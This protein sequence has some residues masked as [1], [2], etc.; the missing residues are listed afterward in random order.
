MLRTFLIYITAITI[1]TAALY[2]AGAQENSG[3]R[4][5]MVEFLES[6]G[7]NKAPVKKSSGS[8]V[9]LPSDNKSENLFNNNDWSEYISGQEKNEYLAAV[10][11]GNVYDDEK[12]NINSYGSIKEN[13]IY[14]NSFYTDKKY[15]QYDEDIAKS[16]VIN[17]GFWPE[18]IVLIHADGTVGNRVS[19][20]IDHDS[21]RQENRYIM[22]YHAVSD[23]EVLREVNAGEIDIKFNHSKYAVYDNTNAKGMGVD[24]TIKKGDFSLKAFG[25]I[26]RGLISVDYFKGNSS[27]GSI[28][29]SDYQFLRKS[30]YQ[31]EPFLRYDGVSVMPSGSAAY[32]LVTVTSKPSNPSTY[33]LNSVNISPSGFQ[34]YIDD[35]N[36]YNNNNAI[37]LSMD[38]GYYTKMVSGS[39]Y[40]VNF[41]TGV[42]HFL[43][44]IPDSSRIFAVYNRTGGTLDPCALSPGDANHP[45]GIFTGKIFVFIKYG[46]SINEDIVTQNLTLDSGE[47]D[48]NNDGK[49]NMDI[50]E[51]RSVYSL[52][53]KQI[54][55]AD[56]SLKFYDENQVMQDSSIEQLSRYKL[57]LTAGTISF[58][59]REP[60]RALLAADKASK[61]YSEIKNLSAYIYSRYRMI[62]DFYA[63]SRSFRLKHGNI[64]EK[65]V[66]VKINEK[67]IPESLYTVDYT[68]GYLAFT[69]SNNPVI[70][71]DAKIEIKYEY[72]PI[73]VNAQNFT[74]GIRTDYDINKILRI[75]GSIIFTKDG[76]TAVIPDAGKESTQTLV[77][78]GDASLKLSKQKLA[79][80]YNLIAKRKKKEIP[81]EFTAYAEYAKSYKD[82]NTFGKAL[83]DNMETTDEIITVSMSEKDWI[84]SSMPGSYSQSD[85]GIL[86]YYFYR[87]PGSPEDLKGEGYNPHVVSYST[88]PGPFNIAMGHVADKITEQS[89]QKSL[90]FD[91]NFSGSTTVVSTVTR[92]LSDSALDLSGMQYVEV[93]VKHTGTATNTVSLYMDIGTVNED[94]DGDGVLDKEDA[95]SNGFIDSEASSGYSE[96]R[97]YT[98]N[99]NNTTKVGSGP[100]LSSS[101]K[102]DGILNTEDLDGDGVLDTT[103]NVYTVSLGAVGTSSTWQK[104]RVPIPWSSLTAAQVLILQ[105]TRSI[106]FYIV[107]GTGTSGRIYLDTLKLVS[108]KWKNPERD[109][110]AL[111]DPAV[112]KSTLVNSINDSD[113]RND[114]FL[115][116][117]T[118]V[119][120]SLYGKEST[121]DI[122]SVSETALQL[123]YDLSTGNNVSFKRTFSKVIDLRYYKTMNIWYNA[124]SIG[125]SNILGFIVGSSDTDYVEY[126]VTPGSTLIWNE[127]KLKL[128]SDSAGSVAKYLVT[129]TPDFKRIKYL[130]VIIYGTG[131]SGKIWLNEIYVS[132]PEK[133]EGDA[134][135]YEF[136]L[137]ILEPLF[138]TESGTPVLSDMNVKFVSKGHSSKFNAVNKTSSDIMESYR[139][140]F[141]SAK[142]LPNWGASIDYINENSATDSLNEEVVDSK[143]GKSTRNFFVVNSAYN[144]IEKNI[145]SV[146]FT[147][148]VEKNKNSK[149]AS[150]EGSEYK[151]AT[152]KIVHT[153]VL[154]YRQELAD[155]LYGKLSLKLM[156]DLSF[157]YNKVNRDSTVLDDA[158]LSSYVPLFESE[159]KQNSD[160]KVECNYS[161]TLF[162][163]NTRL[164]TSSK[165]IVQLKG[166]DDYD[167]TGVYG[168]VKGDFH[169]PFSKSGNFKLME[170]NESTG[171]TCGLKFME[172]LAPEYSID[173]SYRE[174]GFKDYTEADDVSESFTRTKNTNSFLSTGIK[175]PV[176]LR[177]IKLFENVRHLQFSYMRSAY[178]NETEVP[179]EGEGTDFFNEE[180]GFSRVLSGLSSPVYNLI[181]NYPGYYFKGRGNA[182]KGRDIIYGT[183]ND[184]NRIKEI[185]AST[186]YANS[187]KLIDNFSIDFSL[188]AGQFNFSAMSR[189]SQ[190]SERTDV[191]GIPNQVVTLESGFNFEFNLMKIFNFGFFRNN[192]EGLE[193]HTSIL[194]AGLNF[195]DS[196]L[197]TYN[198]NEKKITPSTGIIFKWNRNSLGFK[199]AFDYRKRQ[200]REYINTDLTEGDDD[201]I[202]LSNI[203]GNSAF[204]EEDFGHTFSVVYKTDV[205]W[206]YYFFSSYY[207]LTGIPVFS[208]EYKQ[209]MNRYD[210]FQT[211]SPEPYDL[212]MLT[213]DLIL[214]LHKN[215]QGALTG[216]MAIENYRNR[217]TDGISKQVMSYEVSASLSFIF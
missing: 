193:Y 213:S 22:N 201:Y 123:E 143:R 111:N 2:F 198:I 161:N 80:L 74:G 105:E 125:A 82:I 75:G 189:L 104:I 16:R 210:Y 180:L 51:I 99:G 147:Y 41:T 21:R 173:V 12:V 71:S 96:D 50:Y 55:S 169:I 24:F 61:I 162:F 112:L 163:V 5:K 29:I 128:S 139:E 216:K 206:L 77:L 70:S 31:L 49:V 205:G 200:N 86:N 83:I 13:L 28:K 165:E 78:E 178:F 174:N 156:L 211:V 39:D 120:K 23:D 170:R 186:E 192:G 62:S 20:F 88:K 176:L 36:Q 47:A 35:Q 133:L 69:D 185:D 107:Q 54:L 64:I 214:D 65:S 81:A 188:N 15:Q 183:L 25:S 94:S 66:S 202:Y 57:D 101:T 154:I 110:V 159:K 3:F 141:S 8:S 97:G 167:T 208:I 102:G 194:E 207:Q 116:K 122:D 181:G 215:V 38:G 158:T 168:N 157:A 119:Y 33:T 89:S 204:R 114:S 26:M 135:W 79:E 27:A 103:D 195:A 109:G 17:K 76:Q 172:Y 137:K 85:R 98:F 132:E 7:G 84:L 44:D 100:G 171:L 146:T 166:S 184:N 19:L 32:S 150:T 68:S 52:G 160:S 42:I 37:K 48:V 140:I 60:Y 46:S 212:Y 30:Y 1:T 43:K 40:S 179:Y 138:R 151:E 58:Y 209:Q 93:W 113:Y 199:Y 34:L 129:G 73:G 9:F 177:K 63:E 90:V 106:R 217:D 91:Y 72:L 14:G 67:T 131:T 182:A 95:N 164:N 190:V 175:I 6:T 196:M 121:D 118:G 155:F 115:V 134:Y 59:T 149:A 87:D 4:E 11:E 187:L 53:A 153:P 127:I 92:K 56:F 10:K 117:Q 145:P 126:R 144:S 18:Q 130:K 136:E 191:Y 203:E 148:S 142:I 197:I 152:D 45:N 108:S 124:R